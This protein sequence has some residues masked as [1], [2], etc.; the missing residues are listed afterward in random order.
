MVI[1]LS[2]RGSGVPC[3][4]AGVLGLFFLALFAFSSRSTSSQKVRVQT[5]GKAV[6]GR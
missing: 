2:S 4:M 1:D 3:L 6:A 5:K